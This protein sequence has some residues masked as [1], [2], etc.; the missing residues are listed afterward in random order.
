MNMAFIQSGKQVLRARSPNLKVRSSQCWI[1]VQPP[2][3]HFFF[4]RFLFPY[5]RA[6]GKKKTPVF[7]D[8]SKQSVNKDDG[9][10]KAIR[11]WDDIEHDSEDECTYQR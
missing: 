4:P 11:T 3:G 2:V 6:M 7:R 1:Q 5:D 9:K 10:I 8:G